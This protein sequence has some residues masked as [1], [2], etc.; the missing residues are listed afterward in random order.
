MAT[1][2]PRRF[3]A[4]NWRG[5]GAL[6]GRGVRRF[7][8]EAL[9]SLGGPAVSS[10]LLLAVFALAAGGAVEIVPGMALT[11]F[12][13]PGIA[14]FVLGHAAFEHAAV[15]LLYDKLEGM[16]GDLL[17]APLSP[18]EIL[19]G[20]L[21]A[22]LCNALLV[23]ALVLALAFLFVDLRIYDLSAL[24]GFALAAALLFALL[25]TL[26]GLWAERWERYA[27]AESFLVLPLGFLSGTF[28]TLS[29]LPEAARPL[30][31]FNP[32]FQ[33]VGGVRYAL[34]GYA[35]TA[36]LPG[37]LGLAALDLALWL[38]VWR[39]FAVGYKLKP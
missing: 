4:V 16:I 2:A 18:L 7:F 21:L 32:V 30:I 10:L 24:L 38:L 29:S 11:A 13:A 35:E 25:G 34:T 36:L 26:V 37:A 39:L 20:Y 31:A 14:V 17:A 22:A 28:F 6:A 15:P 3:G 33:A 9:E 12:L 8:K 5:L 19:T 1:P 27:M 23:G